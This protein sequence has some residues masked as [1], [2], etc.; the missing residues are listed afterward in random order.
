LRD[1]IVSGELAPGSALRVEGLARELELST[2]PIRE[3]LARL[4]DEGLVVTRPRSGTRV[5]PLVL[6]LASQAL[7]VIEAMHELAVRASIPRLTMAH[8][9]TLS[10]A[11]ERFREAVESRDYES[12]I[13]ADD[14][15]HGLFVDV[16]NNRPLNETL[17]RYMPT[18]RRAEALRFGT[19]P[20]HESIGAHKAI[21]DAAL[22]GDVTSAV[23]ATRENW[24]SLRAQI[25]L[26]MTD[27]RT[28]G[29]HS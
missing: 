4:R 8:F 11:A 7:A 18:L 25:E 26:S 12:A 2:M 27:E 13:E 29:D 15:F 20:G 22:Q 19:L 3:A 24:D 6:D 10:G 17:A 9:A 16:A 5:A 1:A 14:E 28:T 23:L 21:L